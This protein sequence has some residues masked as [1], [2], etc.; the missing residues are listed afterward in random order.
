LIITEARNIH[1]F[2]RKRTGF[3]HQEFKD[4]V[5]M[6]LTRVDSFC[7]KVNRVETSHHFSKRGSS[8]VRVTKNR[9][10]S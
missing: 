9:D 5:K 1:F 6:T 3:A 7:E 4:M 2:V 10:S 8:R